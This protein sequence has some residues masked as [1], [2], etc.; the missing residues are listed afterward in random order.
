V[1]IADHGIDVKGHQTELGPQARDGAA[2]WIITAF[3]SVSDL[4][5]KPA[6]LSGAFRY[7]GAAGVER[8][9]P[10]DQAIGGSMGVPAA[11]IRP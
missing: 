11:A 8:A 10:V 6:G 9:N 3:R 2:R 1:E 4:Q 7:P 5:E